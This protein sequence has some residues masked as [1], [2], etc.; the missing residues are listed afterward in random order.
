M[1]GFALEWV[2]VMEQ[3]GV[4]IA[5]SLLYFVLLKNVPPLSRAL[6]SAHGLLFLAAFGF[7]S[8]FGGREADARLLT[9]FYVFILLG[10]ASVAYS[11]WVGRKVNP[12][13]HLAQI[14]NISHAVLI[15][16]LAQLRFDPV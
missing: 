4:P 16:Y 5:V 6:G 10:F 8:T 9:V 3:I 2:R 12:I 14:L 11:L 15:V 13:T 1:V 7:A